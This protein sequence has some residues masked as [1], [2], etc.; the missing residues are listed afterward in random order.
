MLKISIDKLDALYNAIA[1]DKELY[2][3]IRKAGQVDYAAYE[4][5]ADV[6]LDTLKTVKSP[7][8]AFFPQFETLYTVNKTIIPVDATAEEGAEDAASTALRS[9]ISITPAERVDKDF[10]IFGIKPCDIKGIEVLDNVFLSEPVDSFYKARRDHG[11]LVSLACNEPEES[12]FCKVFGVDPTDPTKAKADVA[13]WM[14]DGNLYWKAVSE[15]GEALTESVKSL[16]EDSDESAVDSVKASIDSIVNQL[17]NMDLSL[18]K[19]GKGVVKERFDSPVWAQIYN[20]CLGCGTCTFVCPTC[21]CYDIKDYTTKDGIQ[22]YR[23]WDSCMYSDFTLMAGGQNRTSQVQRFRQ[24]FMHKLAY[25][26][27]NNDGMF[28]CVGCGRCVD[29]CPQ[30]LNIVKVIKAFN[31]EKEVQA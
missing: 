22:R 16:L 8:N 3:P 23:C 20:P 1:A 9:K 15:K 6:A 28:A 29:K 21:Q 2:L 19:W 31:N 7:K 4:E 13:I 14:A 10:V 30:S 27:D 18:E 26:P 12:C 11:I 24:R 17:P 25:Y 5:G